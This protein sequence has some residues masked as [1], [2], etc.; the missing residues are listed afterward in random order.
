MPIHFQS[1]IHNN[2]QLNISYPTYRLGNRGGLTFYLNISCTIWTFN[3]KKE[4]ITNLS[5]W[6]EHAQCQI[7]AMM[8][9]QAAN[10]YVG[11]MIRNTFATN[12]GHIILFIHWIAH[13][14]GGWQETRLQLIYTGLIL[15]SLTGSYTCSLSH[16]SF[17]SSCMMD[18]HDK[19]RHYP[20]WIH[21]NLV[22]NEQSFRQD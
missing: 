12:T 4:G 17:R 5:S 18:M 9:K 15:Y 2:R 14:W 22:T 16:I 11:R 10:L 13:K 1:H 3:Q 21:Y 20:W 8:A 7:L 6:I 19:M